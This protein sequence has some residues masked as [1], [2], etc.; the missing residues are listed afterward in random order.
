M[1]EFLVCHATRKPRREQLADLW[2]ALSLRC[3]LKYLIHNSLGGNLTLWTVGDEGAGMPLEAVLVF[4]ALQNP[5]LS[6]AKPGILNPG[7]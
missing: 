2:F 1:S 3:C 5:V 4:C 7:I 6:P